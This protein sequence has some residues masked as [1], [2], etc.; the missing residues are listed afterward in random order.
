[1]SQ[2][3]DERV[4]HRMVFALAQQPRPHANGQLLAS[5]APLMDLQTGEI[6]DSQQERFPDDGYVFWGSV[7]RDVLQPGALVV[8]TLWRASDKFYGAAGQSW[9]QVSQDTDLPN[10]EVFE[11]IKTRLPDDAGLRRLVDGRK[12]LDTTH[13]PLKPFFVWVNNQLVGPFQP[14]RFEYSH[15]PT[16][17]CCQPTD[18]VNSIVRVASGPRLEEFIR[19][20]KGYCEVELSST[21]FH[22][23]KNPN[24]RFYRKYR[25][26]RAADIASLSEATEERMLPTDEFA[27]MKACQLIKG[28]SEK[29][30]AKTVLNDLVKQL[31]AEEQQ[32][33]SGFADV[34][35][36]IAHRDKLSDEVVE[37][38]VIVLSASEVVQ[39][40]IE[41]AVHRRVEE[42][43]V[44]E[45]ERIQAQSI[46]RSEHARVELAQLETEVA[47]LEEARNAKRGELEKYSTKIEVEQN[48]FNK[49][50]EAASQRLSEGRAE[51]LGDISL[52]AP[53]F[54]SF[55]NPSSNGHTVSI[56]RVGLN[57]SAP[58]R[59]TQRTEIETFVGEPLT[60]SDFL[61]QRLSPMLR[62]HGIS[63]A[64]NKVSNLHALLVAS[65]L[66][67]LP[68]V[69]WVIAYAEAMGGTA[70]ASCVTVEPDWMSFSKCYS[71]ELGSALEMAF[72]DPDRLHLVIL[73]GV[74][75]CPSHAWLQPCFQLVSRWR[76]TFPAPSGKRWPDNLRIILTAEKSESCFPL[77]QTWTRWVVPFE[78]QSESTSPICDEANQ[79][80]LPFD[81]WFLKESDSDGDFAF[82]A[83]FKELDLE[84][85]PLD[86]PLRRT[87][88]RRLRD[89]YVRLGQ[90]EDCI[91]RPLKWLLR[92]IE[93]TEQQ[94]K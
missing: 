85:S 70:V 83:L 1:M 24:G 82:D 53:L 71:G 34:V 45:S 33:E 87:L 67:L 10:G 56:Y 52:L 47:K 13:E 65:Q 90:D 11:Y 40:R 26:I 68:D 94:Q 69:S 80:H 27:I 81:R 9:Y 20:E 7:G 43:V 48:R 92:P 89:V 16:S 35:N 63:L 62:A 14:Q 72:A 86:T 88:I 2:P 55:E 30:K 84:R 15:S 23:A 49:V 66:I 60:E 59:T 6:F 29:S 37:Q 38:I 19:T 78:D 32:L 31:R 64:D 39:T 57:G 8:G 25:L 61:S 93:L 41:V 50:I 4:G 76:K 73:D 42:A 17:Y 75:R 5:L 36:E 79:G 91:I 21:I 22:P 58:E 3:T 54:G 28:R 12:M 44:A 51:L 18:A 77:T 74:D 46:E